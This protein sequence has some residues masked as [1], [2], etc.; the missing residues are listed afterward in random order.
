[1]RLKKIHRDEQG[2]TAVEFAITA[3]IFF[4]VLFGIIEGGLL[5]WTQMGLQHGAEMAVRCAGINKIVCGTTS[6]I[7]NY[8]VQ[9]AFGLNP[10]PSTFSVGTSACGTTVTA[11]Y[12][13]NFITTYFG[14]PTVQLNAQSCF[15]S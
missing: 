14:T 8:A 7:Q 4:M 12:T 5:L 13:F 9:Q 15:P 10:P 6:D 1:V 2:A 3:P 11:T